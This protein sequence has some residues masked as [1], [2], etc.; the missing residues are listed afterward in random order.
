M[1]KTLNDLPDNVNLAEIKVMPSE[2]ILKLANEFGN[3]PQSDY[4]YIVGPMMGDWFLSLEPKSAGERRIYPLY[5][6]F[7]PWDELKTWKVI[8]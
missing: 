5:R 7:I 8:E 1:E 3:F 6:E 2:T 4:Y